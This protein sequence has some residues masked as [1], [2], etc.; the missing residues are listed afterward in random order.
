MQSSPSFYVVL[1]ASVG[2]STLSFLG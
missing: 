2:S 1:L